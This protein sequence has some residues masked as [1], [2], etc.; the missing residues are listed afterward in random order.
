MA[1]K[2]KPKSDDNL[3]VYGMLPYFSQELCSY[4]GQIHI[5]DCLE[6]TNETAKEMTRSGAGK[7]GAVIVADHQTAGK[8]R[9][10]K[11]FYSPPNHGLYV[12]FILDPVQL[13][14]STPTLVTAFAAVSVCEA[15]EAVSDK[16]PQIK[17]VNDIFLDGRKICGILTESVTSAGNDNS[18]WLILGIGVN[19]NTPLSEFPEEIR[20]AAGSLFVTENPPITRNQLAAEIINRIVSS[21]NQ[22]GECNMLEK[23]RSRMFLLGETVSVTGTEEAYDAIAID[24]D[25][26]GRLIVK[27]ENGEFISLSAG[28]VSLHLP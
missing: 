25:D 16:S 12:S 9:Y 1:F 2:M 17:W 6:S 19:F 10:G 24:I 7:H 23:Y 20:H 13:G 4:T 22:C 18:Q 14:F 15:I 28:E 21:Y 26:I 8:G 11:T 3:S 27:K 5:Y